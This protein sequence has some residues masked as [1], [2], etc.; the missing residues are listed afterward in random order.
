MTP[1]VRRRYEK[2]LR[3]PLTWSANE[4]GQGGRVYF[5]D[6]EERSFGPDPDGAI[7]GLISRRM[8]GGQYYPSDVIEVF[9]EGDESGVWKAGD[10]VLQRVGMPFGFSLWSM[11]EINLAEK[12]DDVCRIGYLTTAYHH[13]RGIWQA[14][15]SRVDGEVKMVVEGTA[16]PQSWLFW[17]GLPYAR[18]MQR[19]AWRKAL[20]RF[21]YLADV[22]R[23]GSSSAGEKS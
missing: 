1:E 18:Y 6:R 11:V 9:W 16:C 20:D 8:M 21:R 15:L 2:G 4:G 17:I 23:R 12:T 14:T 5:T 3:A 22:F 10:R 7:F 19:R 13:G